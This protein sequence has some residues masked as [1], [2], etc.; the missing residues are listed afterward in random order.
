MV[1]AFALPNSDRHTFLNLAEQCIPSAIVAIAALPI[2]YLFFYL[3][4]L[5]A[6]EGTFVKKQGSEKALHTAQME[7]LPQEM[8]SA[9]RDTLANADAGDLVIVVDPQKDFVSGE[10]QAH[11]ADKTIPR[12]NSV[13]QI[14]MRRKAMVVFTKD[15]HPVDHWSFKSNG[16]PWPTH[17]VMNTT[18]AEFVD[19][20]VVPP[21][22]TTYTFGVEAGAKGYSPLENQALKQLVENPSIKR[23][24][25]LGIALEYCVR[26]TCFACRELG[27]ETYLIMDATASVSLKKHEIE[28]VKSELSTKGVKLES[29]A[30]FGRAAV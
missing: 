22:A 13:V 14:A 3:P 10:L 28:E 6:L 18:G 15:W 11:E 4:G 5:V 24:Y 12:I 9:S 25:V 23:V 26:A 20:L 1:F 7:R 30:N 27:K 17:C 16:G 19:D 8:A 2:I 29:I 21:G